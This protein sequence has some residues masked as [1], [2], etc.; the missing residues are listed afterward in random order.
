[1]KIPRKFKEIIPYTYQNLEF[2]QSNAN[3]VFVRSKHIIFSFAFLQKDWRLIEDLS[4]FHF[5][6]SSIFR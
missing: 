6:K 5:L 1:M 4:E 3:F 2:L